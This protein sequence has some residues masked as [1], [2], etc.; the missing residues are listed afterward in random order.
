MISVIVTGQIA[1]DVAR[2]LK[3]LN[4]CPEGEGPWDLGPD[5]GQD[6]ARV[7][8]TEPQTLEDA[9]NMMRGLI[10]AGLIPP[11]NGDWRLKPDAPPYR[12]GDDVSVEG[13]E[14]E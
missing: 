6:T 1:L 13:T 12:M 5:F 9:A 2:K 14:I 10:I 8:L 7:V 11:M 4:L 3:R